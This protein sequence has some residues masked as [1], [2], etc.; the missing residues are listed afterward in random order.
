MYARVCVLSVICV[1]F[2]G[3]MGARPERMDFCC[4]FQVRRDQHTVQTET[5]YIE[6]M[7]VN[8][9]EL[10]RWRHSIVHFKMHKNRGRS[11]RSFVISSVLSV[12]CAAATFHGT[13]KE[14]CQVS[15]QHGWRC[16][17]RYCLCSL[18]YFDLCLAC[19]S[20]HSILCEQI[21]KEQLNTRIVLVAMETWSSENKISVGD[22]A[23]L[24][25]RDFMKYRKESIKERC[26]AVHLFSYARS[27]AFLLPP[28]VSLS[29]AFSSSF[30]QWEDIYEQPQWGS[31]H[32]GYLFPHQ[33]WRN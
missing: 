18:H 28:Q 24:A 32:W 12:V 9:H 19:S 33:G 13:D 27:L 1:L 11:N 10:V 8:D 7:V 2:E 15:G 26:D 22:D 25:L 31:V 3:D 21:Y 5:K 20:Y 30:S 6:L 14:F 23:L 29:E 4:L 17:W 16:G